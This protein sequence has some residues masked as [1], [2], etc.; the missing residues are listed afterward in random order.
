[1]PYGKNKPCLLLKKQNQRGKNP[2]NKKPHKFLG[3]HSSKLCLEQ[4]KKQYKLETHSGSS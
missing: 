3:V 1:M 4:V 2:L